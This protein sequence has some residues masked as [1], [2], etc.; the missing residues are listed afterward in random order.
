M[1]QE[2]GSRVECDNRPT[3]VF[4]VFF[5]FVWVL[6]ELINRELYKR[7]ELCNLSREL[8]HAELFC[9]ELSLAWVY[10]RLTF[11]VKFRQGINGLFLVI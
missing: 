5:V 1:D 11:S 3:T 9:P 6:P 2:D 8:F 4:R 10:C 7:R